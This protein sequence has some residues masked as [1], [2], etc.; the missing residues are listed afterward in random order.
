MTDDNPQQP[1]SFNQQLLAGGRAHPVVGWV[2]L[3]I[4]VGAAF[5]AG[6]GNDMGLS[7][8]LGV[9]IGAIVGIFFMRWSAKRRYDRGGR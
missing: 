5:G 4:G 7:V 8:G 6:E 9:L 1:K 2:V 3:G